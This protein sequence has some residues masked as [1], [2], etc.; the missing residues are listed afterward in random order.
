ML[1]DVYIH[2]HTPLCLC[3]CIYSIIYIYILEYIMVFVSHG[4][5]SGNPHVYSHIMLDVVTLVK[6]Q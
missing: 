4:F 3:V 5:V 1:N 2:I 6:Q